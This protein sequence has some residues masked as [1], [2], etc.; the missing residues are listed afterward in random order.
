[1]GKAEFAIT[2]V[3]KHLGY[4]RT[5]LTQI[6]CLMHRYA[7]DGVITK[8][9]L[10]EIGQ[11]L[12][13][14]LDG[15]DKPESKVHRFYKKFALDSAKDD[16]MVFDAK[17]LNVAGLMLGGGGWTE[18]TSRLFSIHDPL[19]TDEVSSKLINELFAAMF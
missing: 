18:R 8:E 9:Y 6:D 19:Q 1:M 5:P 12:K 14:N 15:L 13:I 3:E 2:T 17:L 4:F 7:V 16:E 10:Q 11:A